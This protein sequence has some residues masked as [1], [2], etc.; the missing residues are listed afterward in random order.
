MTTG[1]SILGSLTV[2]VLL[3][4]PFHKLMTWL[5]LTP[6]VLDEHGWFWRSCWEGDGD[7]D[8]SRFG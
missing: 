8:D 1:L 4:W 5:G 3:M 6:D 2:I 7:A